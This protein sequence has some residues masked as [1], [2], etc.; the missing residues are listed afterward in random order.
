MTKF[1][2]PARR[3][4]RAK[5]LCNAGAAALIAAVSSAAAIAAAPAPRFEAGLHAGLE[6]GTSFTLIDGAAAKPAGTKQQAAPPPPPPAPTY[7]V[8]DTIVNPLDGTVLIVREVFDFAVRASSV[9]DPDIGNLL[10]LTSVR[11]GDIISSPGD[12]TADPVIPPTVREIASV[13]LHPTNGLVISVTF[14]GGGTRNVVAVA[15]FAPPGAPD[16]PDFVPGAGDANNLIHVTQGAGGR[17]GST[18]ALFVSAGNGRQGGAGGPLTV[19][20]AASEPDITTVSD[21]L[22][23]IVAVSIG[24][25][26][27]R[28]GSGYA[29]ASGGGGGSGGAG[30]D[31]VLTSRVGN[32]STGGDR[33]HGV[34]AQSRSGVAG[35]GGTGYLF[36]SGG[37]GGA[38]SNGGSATIF[39]YSSIQTTGV[40]S[41]GVFAQS[42]GGGAG[43]GGGS[44]GVFGAAGDGDT[45]GNGG[46]ATAWNFGQIGTRGNDAYGVSAQSIGGIGGNSG[47][48]AGLVTFTSNAAPGGSGG[49]ATIHAQTGSSVNTAGNGAYGLFAQSVGGGGG[50]GGF[51]AGFSSLGSNGGAG[52]DGAAAN[53]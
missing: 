19:E 22:P 39:N 50:N 12:P 17:G 53:I 23:G 40:G 32:I 15:N 3:S 10:I 29:G 42:L 44:Y 25:N 18:G 49:E 6:V 8:G 13:T 36:S 1:Q 28:G 20:V 2:A 9:A 33:S 21:N 38:G 41:I 37:A 4:L 27:G 30:G 5:F 52:G 11:V 45:G 34:V 26:G 35:A 47:N 24:G 16:A 31:V 48:S 7:V 14:V 43:A 46:T 51:S